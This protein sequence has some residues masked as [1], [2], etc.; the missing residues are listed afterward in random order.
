[1]KDVLLEVRDA[2]LLT[3]EGGEIPISEGDRRMMALFGNGI[4]CIASGER[5]SSSVNIILKEAKRRGHEFVTFRELSVPEIL[6]IYDEIGTGGEVLGQIDI[7]RQ[8]DIAAILRSAAAQK[9]T[10]VH[11]R[12]LRQYT[13]L[14]IRVFGR[15]KD[16]RTR[17]RDEGMAIVKAVF[18][19][20]SDT[21]GSSSELSSQQGALTPA[22]GLL[23]PGVDLVRLQYSATS[24]GRGGLVM[25][26]KYG[27]RNVD[28]DIDNL[29]YDKG[30]I[31]DIA[32]MRRRTNGLYIISGKVSSGKSTTLQIIMNQM[33]KEKKAE[34]A[35]YTIEEPVELEIPSAIQVAV[36]PGA[37]G[38]DGFADA[39]KDALRSDPNVIVLGEIRSRETAALAVESVMTGHA[40]WSTIHASS[41]LG[42]MDRL[43][44]LDVPRWKIGEPSVVRGLAYQRLVGVICENCRITFTEAIPRGD[45]DLDLAERTGEVL[46]KSLSALFLRGPGC[47]CCF[48][49]LKGRTVVAETVLTDSHLLDLFLSEKR[50][51]MRRYWV[52]PRDQGGLGGTPVMH[53]AMLKVAAGLCDINEIEEEVDLLSAYL[54][55]YPHLLDRLRRDVAAEG[56]TGS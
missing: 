12:V 47:D 29:G 30:H 14:R 56:K 16:F 35:T 42:I 6:K 50:S 20:A 46:G 28:A 24:E 36:K 19:V 38:G 2:V 48:N 8:A 39:I 13:E 31:R 32:V 44:D 53:H 37:N 4:A 3:R 41:A 40:L 43:L 55:E 27:S 26:L 25:R 7:Q 33:Y 23:P 22:S 51:E 10:D 52:T 34:I 45:I 54:H 1:M 17:R 15:M 11:L 5:W 21:K 49:G 9:A 18:A